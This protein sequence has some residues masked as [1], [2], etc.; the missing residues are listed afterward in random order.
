M[1]W[2]YLL[3]WLLPLFAG[4]GLVLAIGGGRRMPGNLCA[5]LGTGF[6]LGVFVA[7]ILCNGIAVILYYRLI[8]TLGSIGA[9]SLGYLKAAFGVLV[10]CFLLGEP[11]TVAIMAGL[12][13]VMVGVAAINEQ[14][15]W[16]GARRVEK[17]A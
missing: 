6:L 17:R 2:Q 15:P 7:G 4:S 12:A 5:M 13:A 8:G 11:L 16:P 9:S 14:F 10:G 1:S 3:A